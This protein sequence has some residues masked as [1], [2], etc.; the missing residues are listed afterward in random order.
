MGEYS[1]FSIL[2][3]EG[4]LSP[5][6]EAEDDGTP[7]ESPTPEGNNDNAGG[8]ENNDASSTDDS[9]GG[10]DDFS[11]DASLDDDSGG[12]DNEG[13]SGS[14]D[15]GSSSGGGEEGSSDEVNKDNTDIF[16]SL[17]AEEQQIKIKE[18]KQLYAQLYSSTDDLMN[19]INN[20]EVNEYNVRFIDKISYTLYTLKN[21][22]S[23]YITTIFPNK[24]YIENDIAFN[25]FLLI[26]KSV[27]ATLEKYENKVEKEDK[28]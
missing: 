11:I 12:D 24:S 9:G 22:I 17:S 4:V 1:I 23:E 15:S 7:E 21:Y 19:K 2:R 14:S 3:K 28:G 5:L 8:E 26:L 13:D 16:T 18:L 20:V 27:S 6:H 10:D 25:R